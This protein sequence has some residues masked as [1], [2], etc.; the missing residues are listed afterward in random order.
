VVLKSREDNLKAEYCR[1]GRRKGIGSVDGLGRVKESK[2]ENRMVMHE[3][4]TANLFCFK[5][6]KR[7]KINWN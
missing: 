7:N 3:L 4:G 2:L 6:K 1:E 5:K